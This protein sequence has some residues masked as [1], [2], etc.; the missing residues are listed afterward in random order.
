MAPPAGL[1]PATPSLEDTRRPPE[2]E[3]SLEIFAFVEMIRTHDDSQWSPVHCE[4]REN[5]R[6]PHSRFASC[7]TANAGERFSQNACSSVASAHRCGLRRT[8]RKKPAAQRPGVT[9]EVRRTKDFHDR[10]IVVDGKTCV[11]VGASIKDAKL[12][13]WCVGSKT[14]GTATHS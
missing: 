2:I 4:R 14:N 13:L 3:V 9:I 12:L 5:M 7:G 6:V 11:Q 1:E 10:F 8:C